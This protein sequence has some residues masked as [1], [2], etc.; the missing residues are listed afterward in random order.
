SDNIATIAHTP[1]ATATAIPHPVLSHPPPSRRAPRRR[2]TAS[3]SQRML[4]PLRPP[5]S[6]HSPTPMSFR[7]PTLSF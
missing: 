5:P 4:Y 2:R 6:R 1:I 7:A 3:T